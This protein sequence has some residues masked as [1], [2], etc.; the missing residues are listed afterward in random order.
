MR[1]AAEHFA[2]ISELE[3][4]AAELIRSETGAES[5]SSPPECLQV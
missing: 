3:T 1:N 4:K 2:T 5:G